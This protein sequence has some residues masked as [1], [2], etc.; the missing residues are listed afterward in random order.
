M[1][2]G[3]EEARVAAEVVGLEVGVMEVEGLG[4]ALAVVL[5]VA[6]VVGWEEAMGVEGEVVRAVAVAVGLGVAVMAEGGLEAGL[7]EGPGVV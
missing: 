3:G 2:E 1:A 6:R 5:E 4:V 7:E